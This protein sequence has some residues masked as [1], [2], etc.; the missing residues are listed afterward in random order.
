MQ[1][2]IKDMA[3]IAFKIYKCVISVQIQF[4]SIL[5]LN[6]AIFNLF[7]NLIGKYHNSFS[8]FACLQDHRRHL[9]PLKLKIQMFLLKFQNDL[10][11]CTID[12]VTF[13]LIE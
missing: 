1:F 11:A 10:L 13:S 9:W 12:P 6:W 2:S 8:L 7:F 3:Q 4:S 5:S